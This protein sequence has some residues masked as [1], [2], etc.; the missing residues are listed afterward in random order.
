MD[1]NG[2]FSR[3]VE[4]GGTVY[5]SGILARNAEGMAEQTRDVLDQIDDLLA[6]IRLTKSNLVS[7]NIWLADITQVD[8]MNSV[9][10]QWVDPENAPVRATVESKL[11]RP[12]ALIEIQVQAVRG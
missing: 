6:K 3:V 8:Q 12:E 10:M 5:F 4:V 11:A 9:W 2:R 1:F 7:A